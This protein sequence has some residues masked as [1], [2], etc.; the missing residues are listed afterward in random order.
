MRNW[1]SR[2]T[3][4]KNY[5][6]LIKK[7][8][9]DIDKIALNK[10]LI[11]EPII[12]KRLCILFP[13]EASLR[14]QEILNSAKER[15]I[16]TLGYSF[17]QIILPITL[18]KKLYNVTSYD[19][20]K[21]I[22]KTIRIA[23]DKG[24]WDTHPHPIPIPVSNNFKIG[25][26]KILMPFTHTPIPSSMIEVV[27]QELNVF[28]RQMKDCMV[29]QY[30]THPADLFVQKI[31]KIAE[32]HFQCSLG[33]ILS[34]YPRFPEGKGA[35]SS[36][37]DLVM[38]IKWCQMI[39]E[40]IQTI[41][42]PQRMTESFLLQIISQKAITIEEFLNQELSEALKLQAEA[43]KASE[44]SLTEKK[45]AH[46]EN[47]TDTKLIPW[48]RSDDSLRGLWQVL[49]DSGCIGPDISYN[50]LCSHFT[51]INKRLKTNNL[52]QPKQK[53]VWKCSL[54]NLIMMI[55]NL[56]E[57]G[58]INVKPFKKRIDSPTAGCISNLINEH[59]CYPGFKEISLSAIRKANQ[60][61]TLDSKIDTNFNITVLRHIR[62]IQ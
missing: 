7:T 16:A 50:F 30:Q 35:S 51:F 8:Y 37:W 39:Q 11:D 48:Y 47:T 29:F 3:D 40:Y 1:L 53:I 5:D 17:A 13:N 32:E 42:E 34:K 9:G 27:K 60:R 28:E 19:E 22:I 14:T 46:S 33:I 4:F 62:S 31:S 41:S 6:D 52:T 59:F 54:K 24:S 23:I 10:P 2:P 45:N 43:E 44:A 15:L 12:T 49:T 56:S 26:N 38:M 21:S 25:Y 57:S 20:V 58:I 61:R 36:E 18:H 55:E